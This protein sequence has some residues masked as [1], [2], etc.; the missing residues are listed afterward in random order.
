MQIQKS[1]FIKALAN[2]ILC[3]KDLGIEASKEGK[4]CGYSIDCQ[5][6]WDE[7]LEEIRN[8]ELIGGIQECQK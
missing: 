5:K 3:P 8:I 7:A 6:C 4:T 2:S 1:E